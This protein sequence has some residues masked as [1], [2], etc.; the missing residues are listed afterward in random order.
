M[1]IAVSGTPGTGKS[2]FARAIARKLGAQ[3]IDL[4]ALIKEKKI[5][6]LDTDGTRIANLPKM[7]KEFVRAIRGSRGPI[8]VEGLL[9]HLL[10]KKY[11]T[12]IIILR[13][14][15]KVLERRL[16]TRRYSKAKTRDNVEAEALD[17]I[18][19]EAVQ[20]HGVSRVYEIDTTKLKPGAAVRLF[21]DALA[22]KISL[23]PGKVNWLEEVF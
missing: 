17:I 18:L 10:P 15:P 7:R 13:T 6:K 19:L 11:L 5:Y 22:G 2:V 1:V 23:G 21:L 12:H 9:A 4:N 3:V 16:R 20:V 14:R 8:V